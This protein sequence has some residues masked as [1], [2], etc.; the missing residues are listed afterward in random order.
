MLVIQYLEQ[1]A[2]ITRPI[3]CSSVANYRLV[4][5]IPNCS[6]A[7]GRHSVGHQIGAYRSSGTCVREVPIDERV[8]LIVGVALHLE[9]QVGWL[10]S[11]CASVSKLAYTEAQLISTIAKRRAIYTSQ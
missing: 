4:S 1:Q 7:R 2:P 10:L 6:Q 5:P 9:A 8:A 11:A 3:V